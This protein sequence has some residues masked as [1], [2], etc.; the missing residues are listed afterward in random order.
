MLK[1]V[2]RAVA[3]AFLFSGFANLLML[4]TP[5][6]TLQIFETVV[7]LGSI[8]TLAILTVIALLAIGALAA[9]EIARDLVL[10][11][12]GLWLDHELGHHVVKNGIQA[13]APAAELRADARALDQLKTLLASQTIV[14][15]F[16]APWVP[17]F[18][19]ALVALHPA[20]GGLAVACCALL[21]LAAV[22]QTL[23]TGALHQES[24]RA[25]ERAESWRG[26]LVANPSL[27]G[28][29]GLA[30]GAGR[31]WES[32]H[33][34]AIA[35]AYSQGKRSSFIRASGRTVRIGSQVA[36]YALGAWLVVKG[37]MT[38][39][40]LVA[41]AILLAR[42]LGPIEHLI[43][44]VRPALGAFA[45]YQRLKALPEHAENRADVT[46]GD[47]AVG[48]IELADVSYYHAG[49]KTP[50]L[51]GVSLS[52]APG[53]CIGIVGP[54]GSGKSTLAGIVAG[55]LVPTSGAAELDGVPITKWQRGAAS[56]PIG[57]VPDEPML[58][59]GSVHENIARFSEQSLMSVARAAIRAGVHELLHAL[60]GGYEFQ[61]G[62][63]GA[64]LAVRERRAVALARAF[65]GAPRVIVLDEPELG[66]DGSGMRRLHAVLSQAKAEGVGL[67]LATQDPRLLR[68]ADR[69]VVMGAGTAQMQ[70]SPDDVLRRIDDR[71]AERRAQGGAA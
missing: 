63:G 21:V 54:N 49:R 31:Q 10:L 15:L 36:L 13:S 29:L 28:A 2:R 51:R 7:P 71:R 14:P 41:S 66:L 33:R 1:Q 17:I 9:I 62:P 8:E 70:G 45:A 25:T 59:D 56:P 30:N 6:Y 69:V 32:H 24:V 60:P 55:A 53:E 61:V 35:S 3:V 64:A 34:A 19:A 47:A 20:V 23:L 46:Q 4:A 44:A 40:A 38:P 67:I 42:A 39:G 52:I 27:T 57:Y 16:D 26:W 11:R 37:E 48:R 50:A 22:A 12:A 43:S 18:L 68:L 5:L 65:C 58:I